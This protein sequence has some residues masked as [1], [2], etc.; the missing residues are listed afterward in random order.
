MRTAIFVA[1][2]L[3]FILD[4][5]CILSR[6]YTGQCDTVDSAHLGDRHTACLSCTGRQ[7]GHG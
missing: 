2:I 3:D 6:R 5:V 1:R 7:K 4:A